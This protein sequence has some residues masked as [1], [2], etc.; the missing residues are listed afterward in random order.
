MNEIQ[1]QYIN[2]LD[3]LGFNEKT[4]KNYGYRVADF[5]YWLANQNITTLNQISQKHITA[6]FDYQE[7][8]PNTKFKNQYL[9]ASFLNDYYTA[10]D[11]L[12]EFLHQI[13]AKTNLVPTNKRITIDQDQRIRQIDPFTIDE[14]R[15]LQ[16]K[17]DDLYLHYSFEH[18][19]LKQE[20]LKLIF[21]LFYACGLR[22][23]EGFKLTIKDIDFNKRTLFIHQAKGY[24]D[25]IIP[26]ND[27]VRKALEHYIYNVRNQVKTPHN[28]LFIHSKIGLS[29]DLKHLHQNC[30]ELQ[31]K[32]LTFHI[33][34][35]SIATHLLQNGM[36]IENI[37]KFLGHSNLTSTQIYTHIANR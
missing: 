20:Q 16:Q 22:L 32:R 19:M 36:N 26:M 30:P 8:R 1:Q 21:V 17:I 28:L 2:W 27:N 5:F 3:S 34:R 9:S 33:L 7:T 18:R 37:A 25:R 24:K 13:G 23:S 15:L 35:H 31:N 29:K 6:F 14:I 11:K 12:C 4:I 10:I